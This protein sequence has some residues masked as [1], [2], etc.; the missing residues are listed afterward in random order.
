MKN[1]IFT[2]TLLLIFCACQNK[3]SQENVASET[4]PEANIYGDQKITLD[5]AVSGQVLIEQLKTQDSVQIKV[6]AK[7]TEVCQVKGCWMDVQLNDSTTM[8]VRFKDYNFFVPMD[9]K[10]KTA[11]IEGISKVVTLSEEWP[12]HK[13][14]DAGSSAEEIAAI[15]GSKTSFSIEKATGVILQ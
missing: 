6:H 14:E 15:T 5:N 11:T 8:L 13:A 12:K 10:G 4:V 9:C 3:P 7:V 1:R 2:Y